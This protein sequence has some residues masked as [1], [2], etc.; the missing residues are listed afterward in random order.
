[1]L[2]HD[3]FRIA[4]N[5]RG[6]TLTCMPN[7][8]YRLDVYVAEAGFGTTERPGIDYQVDQFSY[9]DF[10]QL[11]AGVRRW[12]LR[13]EAELAASPNVRLLFEIDQRVERLEEVLASFPD[14]VADADELEKLRERI[15]EIER[16]AAADLK[17]AGDR[18]G[19]LEAQLAKLHE[20]LDAVRRSAGNMTIRSA[21]RAAV[22]RVWN[23]AKKSSS[24]AEIA[25]AVDTAKALTEA[26]KDLVGE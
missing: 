23:Y 1:M 17:A 6:L 18:F 25:A 2:R 26:A 22:M 12:C 20:E 13:I 5:E 11:I 9:D 16:K 3:D 14:R 19:N 21:V 15:D 4:F 24:P 8:E 10:S 7:P